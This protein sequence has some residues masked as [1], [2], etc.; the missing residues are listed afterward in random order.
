MFQ[1]LWLCLLIELVLARA[2]RLPCNAFDRAC[3][4]P[5][6]AAV[7]G[8]GYAACRLCKGSPEAFPACKQI[9]TTSSNEA[10]IAGID[11]GIKP[12]NAAA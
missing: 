7:C 11:N 8:M 3:K 6:A 9:Q 5:G 1:P 2:P 10:F 4:P 12:L